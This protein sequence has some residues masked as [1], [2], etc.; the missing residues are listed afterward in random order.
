MLKDLLKKAEDHLKDREALKK[1]LSDS[2][3]ELQKSHDSVNVKI[4]ALTSVVTKAEEDIKASLKAASSNPSEESLKAIS[5]HSDELKKAREAVKSTD[6]FEENLLIESS[7][8]RIDVLLKE[9]K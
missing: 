4:R 2:L 6:L 5:I 1:D 8:D 7:I 3:D 9:I